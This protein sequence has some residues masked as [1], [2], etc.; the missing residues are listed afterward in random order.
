M[1]G[2][3]QGK[4]RAGGV[5]PSKRRLEETQ[6]AQLLLL[7]WCCVWRNAWRARWKTPLWTRTH[8]R[9]HRPPRRPRPEGSSPSRWGWERTR[10]FSA[11]SSQEV[12]QQSSNLNHSWTL[13]PARLRAGLRHTPLC[14]CLVQKRKCGGWKSGDVCPARDRDPSCFVP[15]WAATWRVTITQPRSY[16][17]ENRY[18]YTCF[19]LPFIFSYFP[20]SCE[21]SRDLKILTMKISWKM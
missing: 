11:S 8:S 2:R 16:K 21:K 7:L 6:V 4:K 17:R 19:N 20:F 3:D 5:F 18:H 13:T 1:L 12:Q 10:P 15:Q 14:Q 9:R